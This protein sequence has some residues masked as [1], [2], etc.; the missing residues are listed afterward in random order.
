MLTYERTKVPAALA[1]GSAHFDIGT[2]T[3]D[4]FGRARHREVWKAHAADLRNEHADEFVYQALVLHAARAEEL[5]Q[6]GYVPLGAVIGTVLCY[7]AGIEPDCGLD[8]EAATEWAVDGEPVQVRIIGDEQFSRRVQSAAGR[9]HTRGLITKIDSTMYA[10]SVTGRIRTVGGRRSLY[11]TNENLN[12]VQREYDRVLA[13]RDQRAQKVQDDE[14]TTSVVRIALVGPVT[15]RA[16][17][18]SDLKILE[19]LG[20]E[21]KIEEAGEEV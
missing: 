2:T 17:L 1:A 8:G 10:P 3:T 14:P 11:T 18:A 16:Q 6:D 15:D 13:E 20:Y 19:R 7:V 21:Y 4:G 5:G 9:M 12:R